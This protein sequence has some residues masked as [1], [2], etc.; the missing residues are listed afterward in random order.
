M[1]IKFRSSSNIYK[2]IDRC[3]N[4]ADLSQRE[5]FVYVF[6]NEDNMPLTWLGKFIHKSFQRRNGVGFI[7]IY[8]HIYIY[9]LNSC[10]LILSLL[11]TSTSYLRQF[12]SCRPP[13]PVYAFLLLFYYV[14]DDYAYR[15]CAIPSKC[16]L[17][18]N[19]VTFDLIMIHRSVF[20]CF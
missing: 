11:H 9:T 3:P 13:G 12:N 10:T 7:Y 14:S 6:T 4:V 17:N 18:T 20:K 15:T 1:Q 5:Q 16:N 8:I 2:L 19:L